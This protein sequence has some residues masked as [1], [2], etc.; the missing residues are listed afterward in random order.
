MSQV[1]ANSRCRRRLGLTNKGIAIITFSGD[2]KT[3][4]GKVIDGSFTVCTG[5]ARKMFIVMKKEEVRKSKVTAEVKN[6]G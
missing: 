6:E 1:C 4:A 5:C 2:A 3:S